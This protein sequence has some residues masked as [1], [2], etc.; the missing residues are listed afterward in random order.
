MN[1]KVGYAIALAAALV[2]PFVVYPVFLMKVL[3]FALFACAFNLLIGFTGLLS[4]GHAAF[5]GMAGYVA[6]HSIKVM[7]LPFELGLAAGVAVAAL[8][9]VV[10]GGLAIRRQG[11]YFTMITLALA[12]MLYFVC[13]QAPFTG[14]EDGL[15]GVPRGSLLGMID[16]SSDMT[17]YFV[18]LA[19]FIAGFALITRTVHSPFGQVLKAI[20][21]N[22]PRAISLGYDVDKYKLLA[23]VLSGA[24]A[25][26]AGATKTVVLGF[27]TLTD[28]HWSMSGLV[29]LMT[30]VGGLGTLSGPIVGAILIIALE[31][32]LGDFGNFLAS[33]SGIEWFR[34]IGE[35]VTIVT[36]LIFIVCVLAFR[37]GIVGELIEFTKR[38]K[39][40]TA[41][42]RAPVIK[43][44]EG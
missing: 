40:A 21:E 16:L 18:V 19:I 27:E 38:R 33:V 28:V 42:M 36:G 10:M 24:L 12:Q 29:V 6:G 22:E 37:R 43:T 34:S 31:N 26:L 44:A 8:I 23:F 20:K 17:M 25:G 2:A 41:T 1:K 14:G 4:F 32:K 11:I 39:P 9:G 35:S 5:F 13:L 30:L 7:G 15:Q 3:C